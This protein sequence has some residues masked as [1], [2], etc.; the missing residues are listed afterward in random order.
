VEV[1]E[2]AV[3]DQKKSLE[4]LRISQLGPINLPS[5]KCPALVQYRM[6]VI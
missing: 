6:H 3:P 4:I 2:I 1:T 5:E